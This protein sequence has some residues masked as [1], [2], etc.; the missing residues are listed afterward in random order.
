[1]D[2]GEAE[3]VASATGQLAVLGAAG[4]VPTH[5]PEQLYVPVL[6]EVV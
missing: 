2:V 3:S 1:M 5:W 6:A 4:G